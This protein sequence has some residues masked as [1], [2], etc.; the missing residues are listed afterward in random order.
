M[1][2]LDLFDDSGIG[3]RERFRQTESER[4]HGPTDGDVETTA[5]FIGMC[6]DENDHEDASP[7]DF[8][9][10]HPMHLRMV[11]DSLMGRSEAA[12]K[13][14][15]KVSRMKIKTKKL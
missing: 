12:R 14:D 7:L 11:G 5:P 13:A 8:G 9:R 6:P 4:R 2:W 15:G 3:E 1:N 10:S